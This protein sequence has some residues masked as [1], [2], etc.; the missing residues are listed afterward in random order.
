M[1]R[2]PGVMQVDGGGTELDE[3][4]L[5]DAVT[6]QQVAEGVKSTD[7]SARIGNETSSRG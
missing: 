1:V 4:A 6:K 2:N 3:Q 5:I 7:R